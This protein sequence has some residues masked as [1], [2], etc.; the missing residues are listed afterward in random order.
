MVHISA[1]CDHSKDAEPVTYGSYV[2]ALSSR[3]EYAEFDV[4][5]TADDV[6]VVYHDGRAGRGGPLVAH[7]GYQELCDRMGY[8][9][10]RVDEVMALL[11]GRLIGHLD[12]KEIGYEP[13]VVALASSILGPGNFVVTTLGGM[14]RLPAFGNAHQTHI[15][16]IVSEPTAQLLNSA[17]DDGTR[18]LILLASPEFQ[19]K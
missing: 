6:L 18:W 13:E 17:T 15:D 11:E 2:G 5:K 3:A 8:V 10:P 14:Q 7:L 16:G 12:L 9:V 1:H 4:R 19:L